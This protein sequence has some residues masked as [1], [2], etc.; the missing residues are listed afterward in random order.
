MT[1]SHR[2]LNILEERTSLLNLS[3]IK[4][5]N[6]FVKRKTCIAHATLLAGLLVYFSRCSFFPSMLFALSQLGSYFH[7]DDAW[8]FCWKDCNSMVTE[9][10]QVLGHRTNLQIC[11][12]FYFR[13]IILRLIFL[14]SPFLAYISFCY[15]TFNHLDAHF[16]FLAPRRFGV[17]DGHSNGYKGR[18]IVV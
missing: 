18:I 3:Y 2:F 16:K 14:I 4:N 13:C 1:T 11:S 15:H 8:I 10:S 5:N 6:Q 17:G 7:L 12:Q 9:S